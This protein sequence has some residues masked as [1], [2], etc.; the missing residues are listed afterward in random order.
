MV[1][2]SS[3][4]IVLVFNFVFCNFQFPTIWGQCI[5]K[6][7]EKSIKNNELQDIIINKIE[8]LDVLYGPI[9]KKQFSIIIYPLKNQ[10]IQINSPHWNWSL[11]I[12]YYNDKIVIKDISHAHINKSKL[13]QVL[14]H[15][16]NH[17]MVNRITAAKNVPRWFKEG[18]AMY[19]ANE[20][21]MKHK[22]LVSQAILK[23]NLFSLKDLNQ[24]K[25]L[26]KNEFNLAYAQSVVYIE[27][28]VH[29]YGTKILKRV[30]EELKN[31]ID[32]NK[33]IY[34]VT[35]NDIY[36]IETKIIQNIKNKYFL[37]RFVNFPD[38]LFSIMPLLLIIG[39]IIKSNKVKKIKKQWAV[40]EELEDLM[41]ND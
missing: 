41:D 8:K 37:L 24:F 40:E 9:K 7:D 12:T 39:F 13:I 34:N 10:D 2:K 4:I 22:F 30:I 15:E 32:F 31:Q 23:D 35:S 11:G 29:I 21:S 28:L 1:K 33:A 17:L 16:L 5:L 38:I 19:V 26:N 36:Q 18:F 27:N 6:N 14:D 25:N 3:F 20:Q